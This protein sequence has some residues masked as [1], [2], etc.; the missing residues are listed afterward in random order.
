MTDLLKEKMSDTNKGI[1]FKDA[2][3]NVLNWQNLDD[4]KKIPTDENQKV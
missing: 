1:V 3:G 4:I 2:K